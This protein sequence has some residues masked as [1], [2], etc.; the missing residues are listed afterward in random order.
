TEDPDIVGEGVMNEGEFAARLGLAG[1]PTA[2]ETIMLERDMRLVALTES[3]YHAASLTCGEALDVLRR[4]KDQGLHVTASPSLNPPPASINPL[5]L[6]EIDVGPYRTFLK[7]SPPL[8]AEE[9]RAALVA[10]LASG[11][12][13]VVMSDHNPQDVETKRLPFAEAS[14][15][16]IGLE[17]MLTAG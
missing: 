10:A 8:R 4:A 6:N 13:D 9:D 7:L 16:A 17:T 14:P 2:A 11:L 15:G 12:I 1:V 5:T 3:R